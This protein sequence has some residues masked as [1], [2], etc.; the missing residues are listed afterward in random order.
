MFFIASTLSYGSMITVLDWPYVMWAVR[1]ISRPN[2]R[3]LSS[4]RKPAS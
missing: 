4:S 1:V 3:D 2:F